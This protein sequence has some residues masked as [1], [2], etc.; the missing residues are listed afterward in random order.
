MLQ[1]KAAVYCRNSPEGVRLATKPTPTTAAVTAGS[2]LAKVVSAGVNPVDSKFVVCDKLPRWLQPCA[3]W[4]LDG[5]TPGFDFSGVVEQAPPGSRFRQGDH[6]FGTVPPFVGSLQEYVV[7]PEDQ[8]ALKPQHLS[9]HEAAAL[10]LVGITAMQA[11]RDDH[12]L[13]SGQRLLVVGASGGVGHISVQVGKALGAHVTGICSSRNS[14]FVSEECGADVAVSYDNP[15]G[16]V[17]LLKGL[18][19]KQGPFDLVLDCVSSHDPRDMAHG[20][21]RS[22]RG[23][24]FVPAVSTNTDSGVAAEERLLRG[25]YVC[26]GGQTRSWVAAGLKRT[27]GINLFNSGRELFWIRFPR[28]AGVLSDL[29]SLADLGQLRPRVGRVLD[30]SEDG[31]QEA[32]QLLN[33]RRVVGKVVVAVSPAPHENGQKPPTSS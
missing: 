24:T 6:V 4:L 25:M 15:S 22:L 10:P 20:Y 21:E 32:F 30:F 8:L 29:A 14:S 16:P 28:S 5:K 26:F 23:A 17:E 2:V 11:L 18:A 12:K 1:H 33:K 13:S 3:R 7:A 27:V 31:V 19:A 9:F